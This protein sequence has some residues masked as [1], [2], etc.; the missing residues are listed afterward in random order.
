MKELKWLWGYI[1]EHTLKLFFGISMV[2]F[3]T[4]ISTL[5]P[6]ITGDI[7]DKIIVGGEKALLN[8]L[9]I[10]LIVVT[11]GR[12]GSGYAF[13]MLFETISQRTVAKIRKDM[14]TRINSLDFTFFDKTRTGDIMARMTG[15]MEAVR[16]FLAHVLP[17][18]FKCTFHLVFTLGMMFIINFWFA[19]AVVAVAPSVFIISILF[20]RQTKPHFAAIRQQFSKLNSVVQENISG[21]R[22]V[23]AFAKENYEIT[24]FNKENKRFAKRNLEIAKVWEKYVPMLELVCNLMIIVTVLVG[25]I[26][27]V[28]GSITIGELVV[29]NALIVRVNIPLRLVGWL[30]NDFQN[31]SACSDKIMGLLSEE[32]KINDSASSKHNIR[33]NGAIRFENVSFG[34]GD[35]AVLK[36]VSF[37][38]K[39]GEKVAFIGA[40][41]SGKSTIMSL[42]CRFYEP[43]EGRILVDGIEI[44]EIPLKRLRNDISIAMQDIFLFSDTIEGNIAYGLP[45]AT[46]DIVKKVAQ[47]AKADEFI[48]QLPEGYDTIIGERGVGLSGGQRQR[49]ALARTI[50]KNPSIL[51]LDDT[52]SS[53]DL[54]TEY[55]IQ[56][57][58][59]RFC[60]LRTTLIIAHRISSVKNADKIFV[61]DSGQIIESGTQEELINK[62]GTFYEVFQNQLGDFDQVTSKEVG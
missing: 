50:L 44:N 61:M 41:G 59:D 29:F 12:T 34:Y 31:F 15:D 35:E 19:L 46:T 47:M 56:K 33:V 54:E 28:K 53:L 51:I 25:G 13:N 24:K 4:A 55:E 48:S 20:A 11:L 22:V 23:K 30:V 62:R 52:T 17:N 27:V 38:I 1:K 43:E 26:M 14:Y 57:M 45:E 5:I 40:T 21:N 3:F 8:G 60:Q 32:S 39:Q 7:V 2:I 37:E 18:L 49:I 10:A 36:N 42:I 9:L 58:L 16:H 6:Y